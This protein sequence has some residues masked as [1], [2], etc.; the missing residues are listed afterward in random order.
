[1]RFLLKYAYTRVND[2]LYVSE[3]ERLSLCIFFSLSNERC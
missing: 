1:M 3:G 2:A